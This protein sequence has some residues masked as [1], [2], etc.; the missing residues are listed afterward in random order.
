ME[1]ER[2]GGGGRLVHVYSLCFASF[3]RQLFQLSFNLLT[4]YPTVLVA[5]VSFR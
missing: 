5:I 1:G 3:K 2:R 4:T